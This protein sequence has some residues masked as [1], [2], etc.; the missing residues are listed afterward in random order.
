MAV[1]FYFSGSGN[2]LHAA[3]KA[4]AAL[5]DCRLES[6]GSYL[7][8][9]YPVEDDTVGIVFP[10]YCFALPPVVVQFVQ[11]LQANP[12]YCF[13]VA[14]M[15]GNQ[16]RAFKQL[17]ELLAA[18][19]IT[20]NYAKTVLMPD[21]FFGVPHDKRSKMLQAAE[22]ALETLQKDIAGR[23]ND[24]NRVQ[25]NT[26]IKC[27]GGL[28]WW[29]L[30]NIIKVNAL[31]VDAKKCVGCGICEQVCQLQNIT[32]QDGKPVFG[33]NCGSC[34]GCVHW[35]PQSAISAG[36]IKVDGDKRYTHPEINLQTMRG[37]L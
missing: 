27:F 34:L 35:C 9:P 8:A 37:D 7:R 12:Q 31:T 14:T 19:R 30:K 11:A 33:K 10:V 1:I 18:K 28:T 4:A 29:Y 23:M 21:N 32:L 17:S 24:I 22:V 36:K 2:S 16:G 20:L 5:A 6:V 13:G 25:E 15:G 26:L 3:Q